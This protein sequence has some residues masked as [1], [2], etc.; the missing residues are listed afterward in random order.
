VN[1]KNLVPE[2][3][4]KQKAIRVR[5]IIVSFPIFLTKLND[6]F[7][8]RIRTCSNIYFPKKRK[9]SKSNAGSKIHY[10]L[11]KRMTLSFF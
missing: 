2:Q 1:G 6:N 3:F 7:G 10:E 4:G 5:V 9:D 11:M 8:P